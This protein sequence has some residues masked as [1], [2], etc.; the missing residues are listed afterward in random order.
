M[1]ANFSSTISTKNIV[2]QKFGGTSV[3]NAERI[4]HVAQRIVNT[5]RT[6]KQVVVVVSAQGGVTD[7]LL[8]KAREINPI[9]SKRELDMLLCTGEQ[10]AVALMAMAI[11]KLGEP[12][13]SLNAVQIGIQASSI[14]G[15][16]RIKK[17]QTERILAELEKS[18]IVLVAGFQ[19]VN[20]HNDLT[21]LGR[22]ASDTTAVALAAVLGA[23]VCEKYTDVDG[24]YT[25]DPRVVPTAKLIPSIGYDVMLEMASSG[26]KVV[27]DRA[28]E[29]AKKYSVNLLVRSSLTNAPGTWIKEDSGVEQLA[30]SGIAIDRNVGRV[31][32]MGL[33]DR[34]GV[35]FNIFSLLAKA[36]ISVDIILQSVGHSSTRDI[37]FTIHSQ[38][39]HSAI[40]VLEANKEEIGFDMITTDEHLAKIS[41]V[42]AGMATNFGVASAMFEAL[43]SCGVN[44][45]MISTSEI[46]IAVLVDERQVTQAAKAVHDKFDDVFS[47]LE[48]V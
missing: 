44:I 23:G 36:R 3:A 48:R 15:S 1:S 40:E 32:I 35:A 2:V 9:A 7:A 22:G 25:V 29:M 12:A 30:V 31:S 45:K 17:I 28:V 27:H 13:V 38:D 11:H 20:H 47:G 21:T 10:Q 19:G 5:Y 14:H 42:G 26:V 16:A 41:I 34:P 18:N 43:Y 8:E 33:L 37:S 39:L 6:G 24:I 46:K 4:M